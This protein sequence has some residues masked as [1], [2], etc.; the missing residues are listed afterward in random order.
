[1]NAIPSITVEGYRDDH[2]DTLAPYIELSLDELLGS[3]MSALRLAGLDTHKA[4]DLPDDDDTDDANSGDEAPEADSMGARRAQDVKLPELVARG[5]I[6]A[7]TE[8]HLKQGDTTARGIVSAQGEVVVDDVA[9][10]GVT[11]AAKAAIN[12]LRDET[13]RVSPSNGWFAWHIRSL[14]GDVLDTLRHQFVEDR[15]DVDITADDAGAKS[16]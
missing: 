15:T 1:M 6:P 14:D 3:I 16:T 5:L 2:D 7:G 9:Y 4:A 13:A 12:N 8:L 11:T 10:T